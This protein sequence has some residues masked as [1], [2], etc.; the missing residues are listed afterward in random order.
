M[1]QVADGGGSDDD[2]DGAGAVKN[3][4]LLIHRDPTW[5]PA[6]APALA[7][8]SEIYDSAA[9]A[10]RSLDLEFLEKAWA[11]LAKGNPPKKWRW[12]KNPVEAARKALERSGW[13]SKGATTWLDDLGC[14]VELTQ[15]PPRLLQRM[16]RDA[17]ARKKERKSH[18]DLFQGTSRG[19]GAEGAC[20][21][22]RVCIDHIA[23][24]VAKKK[25]EEGLPSALCAAAGGC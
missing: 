12:V 16:L 8:G 5:K 24:N 19:Q 2:A 14:E 9:E 21:G 13:R 22:D 4:T 7:W 3:L 18:T 20:T 15:T 6:V 10:E 23:A 11:E 1:E 17:L 25:W